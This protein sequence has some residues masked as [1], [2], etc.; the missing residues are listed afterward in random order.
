MKR[1]YRLLIILLSLV[2]NVF[3]QQ[4]N[5]TG[6]IRDEKNKPIKRQTIVLGQN[7]PITVKTDGFGLFTIPK[8]N[9]N[10]T[11][12]ITL[13]KGKEV[14]PVPVNGYTYLKIQALSNNPKVEY[15]NEP[16]DEIKKITQRKEKMSFSSTMYRSDIEKSGCQDINC[17][18]SR[19][20]VKMNDGKVIIR[21]SPTLI[22]GSGSLIVVNGLPSNDGSILR[23]F[24]INE[25]EEITVLKDATEY[26]I[27]GS[28]GALI[29]KT[30]Q[31]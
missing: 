8:A 10:E 11:L 23:S 16:D 21:G 19:M 3:A 12:Y 5:L 15:L 13:K 28:E 6:L 31:K 27:K 22:G 30:R 26:G 20:N 17:I 29:I 18:L 14:I 24:H 9:L 7:N 1:N 2:S 4:G 25:I